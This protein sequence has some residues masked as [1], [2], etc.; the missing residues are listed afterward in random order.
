MNT[1]TK[2]ITLR[3]IS[4]LFPGRLLHKLRNW[5]THFS[6]SKIVDGGSLTSKKNYKKVEIRRLRMYF[7]CTKNIPFL[8]FR[9]CEMHS[10]DTSV[11]IAYLNSLLNYIV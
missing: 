6:D 7:V 11:L 3:N 8:L 2:T 9:P 5:I 4:D 10:A 1:A